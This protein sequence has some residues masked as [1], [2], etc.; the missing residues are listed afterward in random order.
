MITKKG[1]WKAARR[2]Y[3]ILGGLLILGFVYLVIVLSPQ[4][5]NETASWFLPVMAFSGLYNIA[6]GLTL[7][8]PGLV[9]GV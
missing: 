7:P 3:H 2:V 9:D 8:W 1:L 4:G 6:Y 5:L